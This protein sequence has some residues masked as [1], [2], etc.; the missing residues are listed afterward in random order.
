MSASLCGHERIDRRC[1]ALY[2][3]IAE[4]LRSKPS[5]LAIALDNLDRWSL[6]PGGSQPY[7]DA[8][9]EILR[10]PIA[11]NPGPY[12]RTDRAHDSDAS[13]HSVRWSFDPERTLGDLRRVWPQRARESMTIQSDFDAASSL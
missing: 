9:R 4:K 11:R 5:L 8:W 7:W 12:A 1:L 6:L 10:R 2:R 13:G 3:A